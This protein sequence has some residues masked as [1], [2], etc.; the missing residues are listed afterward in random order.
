MSML[1]GNSQVLYVLFYYALRQSA[2]MKH[3]NIPLTN[4]QKLSQY[5]HERIIRNNN[6]LINLREQYE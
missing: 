2:A 1:N 4:A 3:I 5:I 6:G